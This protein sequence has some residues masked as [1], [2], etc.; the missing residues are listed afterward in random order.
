VHRRKPEDLLIGVL[1]VALIALVIVA[2]LGV[3]AYMSP[4]AVLP[5]SNSAVCADSNVS[6]PGLLYSQV[7]C[8]AGTTQASRPGGPWTTEAALGIGVNQS[9]SGGAGAFL[10]GCTDVW[11][12]TLTVTLP[13]TP[14]NAPA[15]ELS[16]W[17]VLSVNGAGDT[18]LTYVTESS[19][20]VSAFNGAVLE[21]S[22]LSTF[23]EFGAIPSSVVDSSIVTVAAD[24]SGGS[25]FLASNSVLTTLVGVIGPYWEVEYTTCSLFN[26]SG[27][28]SFFAALFYATN[29][30]AVPGEAGTQ[31]ESC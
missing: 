1:A 26:P 20:S 16:I 12:N 18:L 2:L 30:T 11:E 25:S 19:G 7:T 3:R 29:G 13:A 31:T 4:A 23:T 9:V 21:G 17:L 5:S 22:C 6:S 14:S 28:G 8:T 15:G 27:S 24:D 10:T